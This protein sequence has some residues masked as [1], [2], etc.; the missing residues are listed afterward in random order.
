MVRVKSFAIFIDSMVGKTSVPFGYP[1]RDNLKRE[2]YTLTLNNPNSQKDI[3]YEKFDYNIIK[4]DIN[5]FADTLVNEIWPILRLLYKCHGGYE[6]EILF[7]PEIDLK[8]FGYQYGPGMYT[9]YHHFKI[10][11]DGKWTANF[12]YKFD[13]H[14][15][16][17]N[18]FRDPPPLGRKGPFF[19]QD[20]SRMKSNTAKR[21]RKLAKPTWSI[22]D[23]RDG[24]DFTDLLDEEAYLNK[25]IDFSFEYSYMGQG[26]WSNVEQYEVA[27]SNQSSNETLVEEHKQELEKSQEVTISLDSIKK[28]NATSQTI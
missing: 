3:E 7:N 26:N 9:A 15:E 18:D 5:P 17:P 12:S 25:N 20:Y 22:E 8:E 2:H 6:I 14:V 21:A 24:Q 28:K 4:T 13:Q 19:A 10:D 1:V 16:D 27:V 23:G 11:D